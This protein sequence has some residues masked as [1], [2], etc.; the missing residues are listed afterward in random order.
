MTLR[1]PAAFPAIET[2]LRRDFLLPNRTTDD[3]RIR[4][5]RKCDFVGPETLFSYPRRRQNICSKCE[6]ARDRERYRKD[7]E[8]QRERARTYYR[9]HLEERRACC[10]TYAKSERGRA[11]N[12]AAVARYTDSHPA[13]AAA[14]H[15]VKLALQR[16]DIARSD[17]CEARGCSR[18]SNLHAHHHDYSK[19]LAV[20]WLCRAHHEQVHHV[21]PFRLKATA[22]SKF[23]RAPKR[24]A[25]QKYA[26]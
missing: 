8:K 16:G 14:R 18:S 9:A 11:S 4:T 13:R 22:R 5:C 3:V 26:T 15:L 2:P 10:R 21:G 7:V 17:V 24:A 6:A 23:A 25:P 19:P 20:T 12:R 1:D